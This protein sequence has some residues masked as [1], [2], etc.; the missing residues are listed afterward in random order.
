MGQR[1]D[2]N[3][4][5]IVAN[6]D[7]RSEKSRPTY[8]GMD[9]GVAVRQAVAGQRRTE[10]AL[11]QARARLALLE[12]LVDGMHQ[13]VVNME[14]S[15]FWRVRNQWFDLRKKLRLHPVGASRPFEMPAIP[16]V[17]L[18]EDALYELWLHA[19]MPRA[20]DLERMR[21]A[22]PQLRYRPT[23]SVVMP[24][25]NTPETFLREAIESVLAQ[26][27]PY[28]ELCIADDASTLP[29]VRRVLEEY[30]ALDERI[31]IV[32]RAENGH[33]SRASNSA[34]GSATGDFIA[35]F[36]HDDVLM[37]DALYENAVLLNA[38]PDLDMI[39]SDEDKVDEAG[40]RRE[41]FFK[42][43]WS[44][45]AF[46]SR[47]YT[48][49][50]GVYRRS[51]I[52]AIGGFR[53][54]FDGSQDYDLALRVTEQTDRIGHIPRVLYS[55]RMHRVSA[56]GNVDAKPYAALAGKRALAEALERRGVAAR[57]EDV[58]EYPGNFIVRYEIS[59]PG[60]VSV[61]VPTRD[62]GEDVD[63]CLRSL[64][65]RTTYPDFEV[66]LLDNGSTDLESLATFAE[67][68]RREP[69]RLRTVRYD[70]P[71]NY[72]KINNHAVSQ[73][74]GR[75]VLLLNNDTEIL[76]DDWMTAMVEQA[77]RAPI[78]VVGAK[79]LY[80]DDT[81]QHAG[82]IMGLH[83][84]AG[85]GHRLFPADA[86]GYFVALKTVNNFS[87][88]TAACMMVRRSVYDELGGLDEELTVA[89]NDVD[90]CLRVQRAGYRNVYL[91]HVV[92]YH[93]ESKSRGLDTTP[94]K[95][96]RMNSEH[97]L[98]EERWRVSSLV[99][100]YYNPNLTLDDWNYA[101]RV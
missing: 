38:R 53:P 66:I 41:A 23:F 65:A 56:A 51:I 1:V 9:L 42:P 63:R 84:L 33:I 10:V 37:P 30:A 94:E 77:Q 3:T 83:G 26:V 100:P 44:P 82:V 7:E 67:W 92:L 39:Y 18:A 78:G 57:I 54:E 68:E 40:L 21:A 61:I 29:H 76:T 75:F 62:H 35:L 47:N 91:P 15:R 98:M 101:P 50:L 73:S 25:Y 20:T 32:Y 69:A 88:V 81:I 12:P 46:L 70:V 87:A 99:D 24:T 59:D 31:R 11:R 97:D 13:L 60:R 72:S 71:F 86:P 27:Y 28:W 22:S 49:H 19:N 43:D 6:E 64:F 52:E 8:S 74:S 89:F 79:L 45:E 36:D 95:I 96:A 48:C 16:E 4:D 5:R 34:I 90:F 93:L 17:K 80:S 2:A 58:A 85:H 55:W 14:A